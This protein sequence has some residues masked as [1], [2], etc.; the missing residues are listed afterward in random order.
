[1]NDVDGDHPSKRSCGY[2][3]FAILKQYT[4]FVTEWGDMARQ[5][6]PIETESNRIAF[7]FGH[8]VFYRKMNIHKV[9]GD[10]YALLYIYIYSIG[11]VFLAAMDWFWLDFRCNHRII[12]KLSNKLIP[13]LFQGCVN[14]FCI[15]FHCELP[16]HDPFSCSLP[17]QTIT[18]TNPS[19]SMLICLYSISCSH[20]R[21]NFPFIVSHNSKRM[22]FKT[23]LCRVLINIFFLRFLLWLLLLFVWEFVSLFPHRLFIYLC[24][25]WVQMYD[26][27][28][29]AKQTMYE[30]NDQNA[31]HFNS[32]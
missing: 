14:V 23:T 20:L 15:I 7:D 31:N 11:I 10:W 6:M 29:L 4:Q 16:L 27:R 26:K 9:K 24:C 18:I 12:G 17:L 8:M 28:R 1:M 21:C 22:V 30:A 13:N 32:I 3:T 19:I 2:A 5:T 25:F